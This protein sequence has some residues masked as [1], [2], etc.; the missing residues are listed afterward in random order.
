[1]NDLLIDLVKHGVRL[2]VVDGRLAYDGPAGQVPPELV[3]RIRE[4]KADLLALF[5]EPIPYATCDADAAAELPLYDP[6]R[7]GHTPLPQA[8]SARQAGVDALILTYATGRRVRHWVDL[9]GGQL[10]DDDVLDAVTTDLSKAIE[11]LTT[12]KGAVNA[13]RA[14]PVETRPRPTAPLLAGLTGDTVEQA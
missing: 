1:M 5:A 11:T 4:G 3:Q 2:R 6:A 14:R 10:L 7:E 12:A 9:A 8:Q 13:R